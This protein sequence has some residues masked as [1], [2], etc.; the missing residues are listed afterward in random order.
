LLHAAFNYSSIAVAVCDDD[1]IVCFFNAAL[2][3]LLDTA[4]P[5]VSAEA[6][7]LRGA[8]LLQSLGI[9]DVDMTMAE[10][11]SRGTWRGIAGGG[12]TPPRHVHVAVERFRDPG[13]IGGW[14]ITAR[15]QVGT[16]HPTERELIAR[17]EKLTPRECEVMLALHAGENNKT[18][19]QNLKISPRTVE[20]HRARIMQ[21]FAAK[22]V[23]DL[24]RKVVGEV[25]QRP[26]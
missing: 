20:F 23:V 4:P 9:G 2:A 6:A 12:A 17:S 11:A 26:C 15:E 8:A 1:F 13:S 14:L 3:R 5:T 22:S 18:I 10:I 24:V 19:A 25:Q 21:R 16:R 7:P